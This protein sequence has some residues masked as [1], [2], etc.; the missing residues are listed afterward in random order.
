V[1]R[2]RLA[3]VLLDHDSASHDAAAAFWTG[4]TGVERGETP[5]EEHPF[6]HL[7]ELP[8]GLSLAMQLTGAGTPARVHLDIETDDVDAE[9]ARVVALGA[10]LVERQAEHAVL[11]DPGGVPF[12]VVPVQSREA[13]ERHARTWDAPTAT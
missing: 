12:C 2:S 10:T 13:F 11:T 4:A 8:G 1:H 6:T 7:G 9:V 5:Y 3:V